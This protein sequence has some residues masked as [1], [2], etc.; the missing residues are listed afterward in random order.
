MSAYSTLRSL[1]F[2]SVITCG[3]ITA[4]WNGA[5]NLGWSHDQ[6]RGDVIWVNTDHR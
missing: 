4:G 5:R 2:M 3:L 1:A 6:D